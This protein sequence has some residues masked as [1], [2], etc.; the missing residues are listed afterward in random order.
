LTY[1]HSSMGTRG[2]HGEYHVAE[3]SDQR[4]D[5]ASTVAR[6]FGRLAETVG[7][8]SQILSEQSL[9]PALLNMQDLLMKKNVAREIAQDL[10]N[11]VGRDL[12]GRQVGALQG[13]ALRFFAHQNVIQ[14]ER[15]IQAW[16]S[17]SNEPWRP[18]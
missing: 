10:C 3:Y 14:G 9:A 2:R 1:D 16:R 5:A 18:R 6:L 8:G 4:A 17:R 12:S 13:G 15:T 11:S 7:L